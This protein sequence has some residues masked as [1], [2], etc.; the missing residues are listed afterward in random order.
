MPLPKSTTTVTTLSKLLA[1]ILFI[2]LPFIG[3]WVGMEY[4]KLLTSTEI[5]KCGIESEYGWENE[6]EPPTRC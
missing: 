3:F 2:A 4:Q 1:A 5:N 6:Q